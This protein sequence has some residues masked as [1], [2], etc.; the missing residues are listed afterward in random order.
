M[1]LETFPYDTADYLDTVDSI[2]YYLE[3]ELEENEMPYLARA[4]GTVCRARG[5]VDVVAGESALTIDVLNQAMLEDGPCDRETVTKLMEA[6]RQR[7]ESDS[8][9]A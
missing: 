8:R 4:V 1:A 5:G 6:Y 2:F 9:V 7:M 3:A